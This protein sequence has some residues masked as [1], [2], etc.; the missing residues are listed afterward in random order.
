MSSLARLSSRPLIGWVATFAA[1]AAWAQPSFAT[2]I[3]GG[4]QIPRVTFYTFNVELLNGSATEMSP[5]VAYT[6]QGSG[7]EATIGTTPTPGFIEL[8]LNGPTAQRYAELASNPG[9]LQAVDL[10]APRQAS[11]CFSPARTSLFRSRWPTPP[12]PTSTSR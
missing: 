2:S 5:A 6:T 7:S 3:S 10:G 11:A 9:V 12:R 8:C 4:A 1:L